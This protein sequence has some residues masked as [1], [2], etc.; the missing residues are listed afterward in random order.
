MV[1]VGVNTDGSPRRHFDEMKRAEELSGVLERADFVVLT[2]PLTQRTKCLIGKAELALMKPSAYLINIARGAVVDEQALVAALEQNQIAGAVLD[3]FEQEP[4]PPDH[5][6]WSLDN[7]ILTP[8][9]S[10]RS[11][12]YMTREW[13]LHVLRLPD[14][15]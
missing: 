8:H 2:V 12:M 13:F 6:F 5:P 9:I 11:P 7:V 1:M 3:V 10:G 14:R 4:L 15:S